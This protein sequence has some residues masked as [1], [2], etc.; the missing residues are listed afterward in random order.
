M[1]QRIF[2]LFLL[3]AL[4]GLIL[5]CNVLYPES[6]RSSD[7]ISSPA[8]TGNSI[9][10]GIQTPSSAAQTITEAQS[11]DVLDGTL[12]M[13]YLAG[14]ARIGA[15]P[16]GSSNHK[17]AQDYLISALEEMGYSPKVRLF[18]TRAGCEAANIEVE[19]PGQSTRT[20]LAGA[21]YDT[22]NVGSGVDDNGSGVA[23]LLEAAHRL[24]NIEI[25]YSIRF[26]FFDAEETG[27][28][29][30]ELYA[31]EMTLLDLENTVAM[32]NLDSL[33]VGDHAYIYGNEGKSG[34]IRDWALDYAHLN[35]MDLT[36]QNGKNPAYP[37]GT[38][39]DASDHVPF[40]HRGTQ[41]VYFEATNWDLGSLDGY[42][43]VDE[44]LGEKGEIWHTPFDN[45][46]YIQT[47]FPGRM[48]THLQ[49]FTN[50][51]MH[52]LTEYNESAD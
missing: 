31:S 46:D 38:T 6:P 43:Q 45:M 9:M 20:I 52:I 37:A 1:N 33:A 12:A 8:G 36:T 39:V 3:P 22:V 30:S 32:I 50:V 48:E 19:K 27:M 15:R 11:R 16:A 5:A 41:Y 35:G 28:E 49:L 7:E 4:A 42:T 34:A 18:T 17:A 29:G 25:P 2:P 26:L 44:S 24:K 10:Q 13:E 23:V 21:H 14:L 51:L 47:T 40:L